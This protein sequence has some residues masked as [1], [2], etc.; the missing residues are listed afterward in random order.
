LK[1][2]PT[3]D[4][5]FSYIKSGKPLLP[6]NEIIIS[7][8]IKNNLVS[9]TLNDKDRLILR[10]YNENIDTFKF[11]YNKDAKEWVNEDTQIVI[12]IDDI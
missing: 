3:K 1:N 11:F 6:E 7:S 2:I 12:I 4:I 8:E 9:D 10:A 5:S